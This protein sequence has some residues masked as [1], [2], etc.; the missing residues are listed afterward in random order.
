MPLLRYLGGDQELI[1]PKI[2]RKVVYLHWSE[3]KIPVPMK[4]TRRLLLRSRLP[5]KSKYE[6]NHKVVA[7]FC[8]GVE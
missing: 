7:K 5:L 8:L 3:E 6:A 2:S 4:G 1:F